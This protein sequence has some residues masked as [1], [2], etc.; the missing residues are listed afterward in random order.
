[1]SCTRDLSRTPTKVTGSRRIVEALFRRLITPRGMLGADKSYGYC[2][3]DFLGETVTAADI[4]A[5]RQGIAAEFL[6]EE[7]VRRVQVDATWTA[8]TR[9][10]R[11][12]IQAVGPDGSFGFDASSSDGSGL[13]LES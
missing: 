7:C 4:A 2:V 3:E 11:L 10:L 1:M 8:S 13:V 6:K 12:R 9:T 5:L